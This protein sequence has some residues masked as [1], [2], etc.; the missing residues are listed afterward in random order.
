M[1]VQVPPSAPKKEAAKMR[2]LFLCRIGGSKPVCAVHGVCKQKGCTILPLGGKTDEGNVSFYNLRTAR[3][4]DS[5]LTFQRNFECPRLRRLRITNKFKPQ[6]CG[7]FFWVEYGGSEPVCALHGVNKQ[8]GC[9]ILPLG[10]KT[11]EGNVSFYDLRTV[12]RPDSALTFQR[13]F[14]CPRLRHLRITNK[15]KP[16]KCGFFFRSFANIKLKRKIK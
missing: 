10:G 1:R 7:F 11:D 16:Q 4:P 14:E 9:T 2:F 8:K 6:K 12:R 15:L 3:R 5:A 13:N